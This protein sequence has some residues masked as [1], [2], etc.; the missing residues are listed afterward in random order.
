VL[1]IEQAEAAIEAGASFIVTPA[2]TRASW[3]SASREHADRSGSQFPS[4]IEQGL[5]RGLQ[6]LKFFPAEASGG[7]KMLKAL[8]GPYA[9]V[10]FIPTGGVDVTTSNP[11]S[12]CPMS[13]PW[14]A[15]G[16]STRNSSPRATSTK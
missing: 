2:S 12:G 4:Q 13:P 14:A 1:T 3:N 8:H 7:V 15:P 11:I 16:W 5:E 6:L 9:E 10:C